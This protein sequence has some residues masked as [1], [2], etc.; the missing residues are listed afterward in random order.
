M[1][2]ERTGDDTRPLESKGEDRI[3]LLSGARNHL[4]RRVCSQRYGKRLVIT[5]PSIDPINHSHSMEKP[6]L[7]IESD[8]CMGVYRT[9]LQKVGKSQ[10]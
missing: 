5:Q 7:N 4:A 6:F 1:P 9:L 3:L 2:Q 10:D 8:L